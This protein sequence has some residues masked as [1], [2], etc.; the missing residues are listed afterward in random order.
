[1]RLA[2]SYYGRNW[3]MYV[4]YGTQDYTGDCGKQVADFIKSFVDKCV[5]LDREKLFISSIN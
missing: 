3:K 1:M 4:L 2:A 5:Q